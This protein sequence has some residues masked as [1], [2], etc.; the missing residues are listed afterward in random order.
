[1]PRSSMTAVVWLPSAVRVA[2]IVCSS[3]SPSPRVRTSSRRGGSHAST[4]PVP[5]Q[6]LAKNV[7]RNS[8]PRRRS[9]P[10][11]PSQRPRRAGSV[12]ADHRSSMSVSSDPPCAPRPCRRPWPECR[13]CGCRRPRRSCRAPSFAFP[14]GHL[15]VQGVQPLLPQGPVPAEPLVH[16]GER[17][18]PQAV[19]APLGI[20]ADLDEPRFT[21]HP[22]VP[23]HPRAGDRQQGRQLAC[24]GRPVGQGLEQRP[25]AL[26]RNR[27]ENSFHGPSVPERLR[28]CQGTY[29]PPAVPSYV[30][31][32]LRNGPRN[33][34]V[35]AVPRRVTS[36]SPAANVSGSSPSTV[37][38]TEPSSTTYSS[39][40]GYDGS[41]SV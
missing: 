34:S 21:Q 17:L 10:T 24:G 13:E 9:P 28:N 26:V 36:A 23:R 15:G 7:A 1:M 14:P 11:S 29:E 38:T 18:G 33:S 4:R 37:T 39:S 41:R 2:S 8:P 31:K 35:Q 12:S 40:S 32:T 20:A 5:S 19:H 25:P 3:A 22:Q 16:L 6:P 27:P 30:R